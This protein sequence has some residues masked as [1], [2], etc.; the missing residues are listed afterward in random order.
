MKQLTIA[1]V[2]VTTSEAR[3]WEGGGKHGKFPVPG[4]QRD[5]YEYV[6]VKRLHVFLQ[7]RR[8]PQSGCQDEKLA[9]SCFQIR[10]EANTRD[11]HRSLKC[12]VSTGQ[13]V[14]NDSGSRKK[15]R[16]LEQDMKTGVSIIASPFESAAPY[17]HSD[18]RW[19]SMFGKFC[20]A[21]CVVGVN[22]RLRACKFRYHWSTAG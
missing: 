8:P 17:R 5:E 1:A 22:N 20:H 2:I 21:W 3:R 18:E 6:L 4:T 13:S 16:E 11:L 19:R 10:E 12:G 7:R 14:Q 9:V 15:S